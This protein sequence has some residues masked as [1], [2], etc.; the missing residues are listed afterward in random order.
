MSSVQTL[1][2]E[3][4]ARIDDGLLELPLLPGVAAEVMELCNDEEVGA[5]VLAAR[6]QADPALAGHVLAAANC[7]LYAP[8]EPIVSLQQAV[9]RLGFATLSEITVSVALHGAVFSVP[10]FESLLGGIWTHSASAGAWSKEVA[11]A[12]RANVEGAYLCGLLHDIG[13]PIG[14]QL[15]VDVA[16]AAG[17]ELTADVLVPVLDEVHAELGARLVESWELSDWVAAAA[18]HHHDPEA[19]PEHLDVVRTV[20]LADALAHWSLGGADGPPPVDHPCLGPLDLYAEEL[21]ALLRHR[22]EVA[23]F[24]RLCS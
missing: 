10:G 22:G 13:R 4:Q 1:R 6:L 17:V 7:A 14:L 19:A 16:E 12:R 3:L 15:L 8:T 2:T 5:G 9:S 24:A 20:A 21:D 23:D 11:R 18:R